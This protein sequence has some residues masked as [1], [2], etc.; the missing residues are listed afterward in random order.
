ML[1]KTIR[2]ANLKDISEIREDL[3]YWLSKSPQER[4]TAVERLRREHHG[5][6]ERLKELLALF[7]DHKVDYIIV[8]AF[9]LAYH[10]APRYTGDLDILVRPDEENA[11]CILRALEVFGFGS[12]GLS[13]EDFTSSER[14]VQLGVPP[15]RIDIVTSITGVYWHEAAQ[16]RRPGNYGEVPVFYLGKKEF[17]KNKRTLGRM[18][19]LADVEAIE[20]GLNNE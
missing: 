20:D 5:D 1:T 19:D 11:Q 3:V 13:A 9:A 8:G 7:N 6:S 10:G 4:I 17:V 14:I 18:K 2:K 16:G 12:L 15:V